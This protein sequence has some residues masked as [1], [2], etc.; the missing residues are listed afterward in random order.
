[1]EYTVSEEDIITLVEGIGYIAALDFSQKIDVSDESS[2][3]SGIALGLNM[4][5]E[6]LKA[7]VVS[8]SELEEKNEALESLAHE[9][10]LM[11]EQMSTPIAKLWEGILF[12]PLIGTITTSRMQDVLK[13]ILE[14]IS[15]TQSK[16]F[17]LDI[18]GVRLI[19]TFIANQFVRI[20]KATRL[21]GCNCILSGIAPQAAQTMVELGINTEELIT[22]NTMNDAIALAFSTTNYKV[23]KK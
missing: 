11:I 12:L 3:L 1:M 18:S 13:G 7:S 15:K 20:A 19:D 17:I 22:T 10:R 21:M 5:A 6:E 9:Q 4:L 2:P 8:K 23:V 14:S 16:I